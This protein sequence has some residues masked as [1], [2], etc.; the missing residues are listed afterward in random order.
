MFELLDYELVTQYCL[1]DLN[2][3]LY[4]MS[5]K[6]GSDL[7]IKGGDFIWLSIYGRKE[8]VTKR[9]LKE[10]E[11]NGLIQQI[12]GDNA[13]SVLGSR[14]P[15]D[16]QYEFKREIESPDGIARKKRLRFRVNAV[17]CQ[18]NGKNSLV[19]TMRTIPTTPPSVNEINVEKEIVDCCRTADQ[20][21]ILI[22]GAT[23]NGKSTLL[24][25]ILR[26][27]LEDPDG[28]RNMV[29][30]ES[31]I[32]F[33][34]DTIESESSFITQL[35]VGRHIDSFHD[36]VVNSLRMAPTT[37]LVGE[38]RDYETISSAINASS[39][40]HV[41]FSTVHANSVAETFQRMISEY[42]REMQHQAT[43][44]LVQATKMIVAQRLIKTADGKRTAIREI[45]ILNQEIKNALLSC[46][47]IAEE[48][49]GIVE[50]YGKS[51]M[52]DVKTRFEDGIITEKMYE[53]MKANYL[54]ESGG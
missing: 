47:N 31:P 32:E 26:D 36:G 54:L 34:Y 13:K 4:Q 39:T 51:M 49:F 6:G 18:R 5:E 45:L 22:V 3:M 53:R 40:G 11:V 38:A 20:G 14:K 50:K 25:S 44:N 24:A 9:S 17:G 2:N 46:D 8:K 52:V 15:I 23:G 29:T 19:I 21:L 28:H 30:I 16:T 37:I 10:N 42:P 7:F 12:Y 43:Y 41:V 35:E 27:Q 48:A 33:V 1:D